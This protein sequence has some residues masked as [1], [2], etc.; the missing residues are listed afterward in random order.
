VGGKSQ[1]GPFNDVGDENQREP[2]EF[3]ARRFASYEVPLQV[4]S[5]R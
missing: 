4:T 3:V 2:V 1:A 5:R